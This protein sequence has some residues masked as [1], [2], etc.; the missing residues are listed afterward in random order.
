MI[1]SLND[2]FDKKYSAKSNNLRL[3][4]KLFQNSDIQNL[5]LKNQFL[6]FN[7]KT[8]DGRIIISLEDMQYRVFTLELIEN[9]YKNLVK[10]N[11][12]IN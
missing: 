9:T 8:I 1:S 6:V 10:I 2:E 4:S 5:F 11:D 3:T 12:Q 7:I